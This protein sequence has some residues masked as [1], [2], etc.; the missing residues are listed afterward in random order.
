MRAESS[1]PCWRVADN[2]NDRTIVCQEQSQREPLLH[3]LPDLIPR[4]LNQVVRI[5][6]IKVPTATS[7]AIK[8]GTVGTGRIEPTV[9]KCFPVVRSNGV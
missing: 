4:D 1:V 6:V 3:R 8:W 9:G 2:I 5:S 7:Q